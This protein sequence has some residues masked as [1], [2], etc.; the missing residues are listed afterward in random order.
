MHHD[1]S[2]KF[3]TWTRK[4]CTNH[5]VCVVKTSLVKVFVIF[6]YYVP[7]IDPSYDSEQYKSLLDIANAKDEE[8]KDRMP[9]GYLQFR[10]GYLFY[11]LITLFFNI[12]LRV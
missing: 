11:F 8:I 1:E 7:D 2:V 6:L 10:V 5:G 9:M 3:F 12:F 4:L